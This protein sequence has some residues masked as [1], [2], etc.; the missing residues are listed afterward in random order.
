MLEYWYVA[1]NFA[2]KWDMDFIMKNIFCSLQFQEYFCLGWAWLSDLPVKS[3][4]SISE[5]NKQPRNPLVRRPLI[6]D[7][8]S[9]FTAYPIFS[10]YMLYLQKSVIWVD[11]SG[12]G[13]IVKS[14]SFLGPASNLDLLVTVGQLVVL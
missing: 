3:C 4:F 9:F 7:K 8:L 6:N 2:A 5:C 1:Q 12:L 10:V 13:Y 14:I 11:L